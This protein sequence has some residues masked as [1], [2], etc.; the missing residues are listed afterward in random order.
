MSSD[1]R[2][3]APLAAALAFLGVSTACT[4][5]ASPTVDTSPASPTGSTSPASP[6]ASTS[7]SHNASASASASPSR[8]PAP[9]GDPVTVDLTIAGS[10]VS[11]SGKR[12][13][14]AKGQAVIFRVTSD[15]DDEIHAHLGGGLVIKVKAG[16]LA[17]ARMVAEESGSFE[18]ESHH[19]G[20]IF[21]ILI[22]R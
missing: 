9:A 14:V 17:S 4:S 13:N 19:L 20:K 15:S 8:T 6:T 21:V 11:P 7:A 12:V 22:V 1:T 18:V 10:K 16:V 3:I 5:P 2:R